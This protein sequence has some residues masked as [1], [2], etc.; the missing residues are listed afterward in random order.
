MNDWLAANMDS[1]SEH[2]PLKRAIQRFTSKKSIAAGSLISEGGT[3]M[4]SW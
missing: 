3:I 2:G 1:Q 4:S